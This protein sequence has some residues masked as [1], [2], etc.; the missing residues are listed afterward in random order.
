MF[1]LLAI[2][3]H[4]IRHADLVPRWVGAF[5]AVDGM[6]IAL[7][8]VMHLSYDGSDLFDAVALY[9]RSYS[10]SWAS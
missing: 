5:P 10:T 7:C 3:I 2:P 8:G 6:G 9:R 4:I 1:L